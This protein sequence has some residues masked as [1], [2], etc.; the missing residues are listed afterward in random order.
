MKYADPLLENMSPD[1][2]EAELEA[3]LHEA[4]C[5]VETDL[6]K[7]GK[8]LFARKLDDGD[9]QKYEAEFN[10]FFEKANDLNQS[11]LVRYVCHRKIILEFLKKLLELRNNEKYHLEESLHNTI[12]PLGKTLEDAPEC[13]HNLWVLDEKLVYH[14]FLASDK[15]LRM[16]TEGTESQSEP[17]I[18]ST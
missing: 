13:S 6:I 5:H 3:K 11:D 18:I 1:A 4:Y 15:Q 10:E 8:E 9:V 17:D 2:D 7:E 12:F 14:D 16:T